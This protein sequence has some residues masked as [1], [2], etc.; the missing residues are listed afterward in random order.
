MSS[1]YRAIADREGFIAV[2]PDGIDN[3]WDIGP[4]CT[5]SEVDDLAF[6]R[7]M[8]TQIESEACIDP[9]RIYA[10]GTSMGGGMSQF[11]ACNAGDLIAA[12]APAAFDLLIPEEEPCDP[13]R[14]I[15]VIAFRGTEDTVVP[16]AG[17]KGPSGRVTFLGA[18]ANFE[19]WS[20]LDGCSGTATTDEN[21]CT[22]QEECGA[23]V[24]VALCVKQGGGHAHGDA[25]VG[26]KFMQRYTLPQ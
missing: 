17:G 13:V 8:V 26:W 16:Y 25:E 23:G 3:A 10:T 14:P 19:R 6:V 1:G 22:V 21:G 15:S 5:N 7:A 9:S 18:Q 12:V 20:E 11:L 24:Q 4:C 2:Y